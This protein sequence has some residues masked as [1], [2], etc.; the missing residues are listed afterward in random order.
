MLLP[1]LCE[2]VLLPTVLILY[3]DVNYL[4]D[5]IA[6]YFIAVS[7]KTTFWTSIYNG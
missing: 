2:L 7:V 5:V 6:S 1:L 4:A 3:Y